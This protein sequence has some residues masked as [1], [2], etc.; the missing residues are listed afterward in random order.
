M[1][2][3]PRNYYLED[4]FD[5]WI[6]PKNTNLK[7]DIYEKDGNYH[8]EIDIPGFDKKDI[9]IEENNG[10]L[11][12][13]AQKEKINTNDENKTYIHRERQYSKYQRSFYIGDVNQDSINAKYNNGT[14]SVIVPKTNETP[15]KHN[16][17]I[18]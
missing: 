15:T 9:N 11:T 16:I 8:I 7:C 5:D 2:L 10:Y 3:I 18:N 12:I 4:F 14:L 17:Q 13:T 1:N 6:N